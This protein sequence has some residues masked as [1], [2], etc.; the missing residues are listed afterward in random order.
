MIPYDRSVSVRSRIVYGIAVGMLGAAAG[1]ASGGASSSGG[2][3]SVA[4]AAGAGEVGPAFL[5]WTGRFQA[6]QMQS[7]DV[8]A[9]GL[10][11]ATGSVTLTAAGPNQTR[12]QLTVSGPTTDPVQLPWAISPGACRSG[13]IPVMTV[14]QFPEITMSNGRGELDATLSMPMPTAGTY[15]VNVYNGSTQDESGVMTCAEL[16]L[17]RKGN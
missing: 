14:S 8:A 15:H 5:K 16:R 7:G 3:P 11:Q 9:R 13:T 1:C 10:N 6:T 2:S 12:V 17:E 4:M